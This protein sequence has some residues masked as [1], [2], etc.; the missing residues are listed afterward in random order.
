MRLSRTFL[1]AVAAFGLSVTSL[2]FGCHANMLD[3][4]IFRPDPMPAARPWHGTAPVEVVA[5]T[6]DGLELR[7]YWWP[8]KRRDGLVFVFFHGQSGNRYSAAQMAAPLSQEGDGLL[9]ASYR[10][11]GDNPGRPS[12]TGV[13]SDGDAFVRLATKLAPLSKL[14]T[15][16]FSLGSSVALHAAISDRVGGV[17]T[18]GAFTRLSALAPALAKP[19]IG[20]MFDNVRLLRLMGKPLLLVHGTDDRT[21]PI[22]QANELAGTEGAHVRRL[23]INGA[24]HHMDF[25]QV[26][27][28]IL[29]NV[30]QMPQRNR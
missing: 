1:I 27:P 21:V 28:L 12:E 16:G 18:I 24:P 13:L 6:S 8:P 15:C 10:G 11:Y 26:A 7:G 30:R 2:S 9:V 22:A 20:D 5:R 19:I 3:W 29:E 14:I 4:R 23:N 25:G 17:V